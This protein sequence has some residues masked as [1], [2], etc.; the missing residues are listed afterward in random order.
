MPTSP[1]TNPKAFPGSMHLFQFRGIDV[2][3][4]FSWAIIAYFRITSNVRNY[5][6]IFYNIIEY[7]TLFAI[8][9]AHE[10]G[11][12]LACRSV[13]GRAD[14]ILLWPLG[15]V[16][17]VDPPNRPGAHLWSIAAGPLVNV[18]LAPVTLLASAYIGVLFPESPRDLRMYFE[19][20]AYINLVL[21]IFNMLPIYPLD[22]GQIVRSLLWYVIGP[23]RSLSVSAILGMVG[24]VVVIGLAVWAQ[25]V[26]LIVLAVFGLS[27]CMAGFKA[28][29]TLGM[30][31]R[32][33]RHEGYAC[34]TCREAPPVGP[35][36]MCACGG[37]FDT[38]VTGFA[39]PQCGQ[40]YLETTCPFCRAKSLGPE[41]LPPGAAPTATPVPPIANGSP[42][43]WAIPSE[44]R[45]DHS[46]DQR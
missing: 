17:Y 11:H 37:Q 29:K 26:W 2:F 33:P 45:H 10:F 9:T 8:V 36:W 43:G 12:A 25:N 18:V 7:L 20:V 19:T 16:A 6:H 3:V 21:L 32:I 24:A 34:P 31:R 39:C 22:G 1:S 35:Y 30:M 4:H 5:H 28:A 38:F 42:T 40:R 41:W 46:G 27:Q 13:G 15:G 14:R 44:P 23:V